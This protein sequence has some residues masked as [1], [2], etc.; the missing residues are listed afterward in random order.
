MVHDLFYKR[1][2][3]IIEQKKRLSNDVVEVM[4]I[5]LTA[6]LTKDQALAAK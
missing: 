4:I 3:S 1:N 5:E 2:I 6:H